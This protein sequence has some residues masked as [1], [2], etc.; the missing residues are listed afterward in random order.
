MKLEYC[1]DLINDEIENSLAISNKQPQNLYAPI[2][3]I[4]SIGGKRIRPS[5]VLLACNLF[6]DDIK[7]AIKPALALEVFHNFTLLHDDIMDKASKRRGKQT[8]HEKWSENIAILSG[9]AMSIMAY[10]LLQQTKAEFLPEILRVFN[11]TALEVCDGQQYDMDY[12]D[13]QDIAIDDYLNMIRLKTSVLIAGSLK[14]G[15][16]LGGAGKN[17]S[18]LMYDFGLNL[19]LSFQLR[20]DY[21]DVFGDEE[22][23]GKNIG[24][25]IVANKKTYLLLKAFELANEMQKQKLSRLLSTITFDREEKISSVKK[26]YSNLQVADHLKIKMEDYYKKSLAAFDAVNIDPS[27]KEELKKFAANLMKRDK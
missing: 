13:S 6:S 25:D 22:T 3:Y 14:I 20:D 8:V 23:F 7:H 1:H 18:D 9:D 16:I 19:G 17:D 12:E 21:L 10:E 15:A 2:S 5:L 26:I 24:G 4:L 11:Q 27:K